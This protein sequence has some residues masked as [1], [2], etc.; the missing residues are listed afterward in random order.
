MD[1]PISTAETARRRRR[2]TIAWAG[3]AAAVVAVAF[4]LS[5]LGR[6]A[7]TV[8]LKGLWLDTVKQG[9]MA[10][11]LRGV[12]ELVP[13]D[14]ASRW[15]AAELD[16]RV[17]RKLLEAGAEVTATTVLLQLSNPDIEQAAVAA[18]LAL[19]AAQAAYTSLEASLENELLALRSAAAAIEAERVQAAMQ[20]EVDAA[21]SRE[22][23]LSE[24]T[25]RQS[26]VR[27]DALTTR[28]TLEQNRIAATERSLNTR[29]ATQRSEV[30][31]RR[32]V[33][34]L[35]RRDVE[36]MTVRAGMAGVLQ[37]VV[38]EVGQR[39]IRSANLARVIDPV[40]LK[41][42]V[43][44]PEAQTDDL[45][46]GLTVAIDTHNGVVPGRVSRIAPA[47]ENGTVTV[48]VELRGQLPRGARPDMTVDGI[49]EL[50][51]L[52]NVRS[53]GRPA[54]GQ[55]EGMV[56]LY[57]V[58]ADGATAER[59][60]VRLGRASANSVEIVEGHLRAG[61]QVVLSDTSSWADQP[62]VR[63]R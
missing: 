46:L 45:R 6:A 59:I 14:D 3:S 36:S 16:G 31:S 7:P 18:D 15:V 57:K 63:L 8:D 48:D 33:A 30:D 32:T 52:R 11:E 34:A 58:S 62:V 25:S 20:A 41:A 9:D 53:M 35:K 10:R 27:A 37:Q 38:V 47:A 44:I 26:K 1:V 40:R 17:D 55:T 50:E 4:G 2:R 23:L 19:Q 51:R 49:I 61:D 54:S 28:A 12:G 42:Q 22:G 39:V 21:L 24:I 5:R 43:R 29:L 60:D 13:D 56:P